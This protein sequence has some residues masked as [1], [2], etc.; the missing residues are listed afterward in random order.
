MTVLAQREV[1][2]RSLAEPSLHTPARSASLSLTCSLPLQRTN[3]PGWPER[4]TAGL[5]AAKARGRLSG[6]PH[7][8]AEGKP[9]TA[10][11]LRS[12]GE[13]KG[14]SRK[15]GLCAL[16][17]LCFDIAFGTFRLREP[18][19]PIVIFRSRLHGSQKSP[20]PGPNGGHSLVGDPYTGKC[21]TPSDHR[22]PPSSDQNHRRG[23]VPV[24]RMWDSC[25]GA[26][27]VSSFDHHTR[28]QK[29]S[30]DQWSKV[31]SR[32]RR[33]AAGETDMMMNLPPRTWKPWSR[34]RLWKDRSMVAISWGSASSKFPTS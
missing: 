4:P 20:A 23:R 24:P 7:T 8:M 10:R 30:P 19:R 25:T 3:V 15:S 12:E 33:A 14:P 21:A 27:T 22:M 31:Y 11:Q 34:P 5:A 16:S 6:G 18:P 17:G 1:G 9:E 13:S 28:S 29:V 2:F 26:G 32:T